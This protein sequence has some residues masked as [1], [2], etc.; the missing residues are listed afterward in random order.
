[1]RRRSAGVNLAISSVGKAAVGNT[2]TRTTDG[3]DGH[4]LL[5]TPFRKLRLEHRDGAKTRLIP[6]RFPHDAKNFSWNPDPAK[7]R[8]KEGW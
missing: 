5:A 4:I 1:M 3:S 6:G 8:L 7:V 2:A